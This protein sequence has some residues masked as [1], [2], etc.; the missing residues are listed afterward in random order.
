MFLHYINAIHPT[1]GVW[2]IPHRLLPFP[3]YDQQIEL[4]VKHLLGEIQ[5]PST[6]QMLEESEADLKLRLSKGIELKHAHNMVYPDLL[7][8][9]EDRMCELGKLRPITQ[10]HRKI[11]DMLVKIRT[12]DPADYKSNVFEIASDGSVSYSKQRR[13]P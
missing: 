10:S 6:K 3:M 5:L 2:S 8:A 7:W 9:Y 13:R 11:F 1:M 12:E 4:F